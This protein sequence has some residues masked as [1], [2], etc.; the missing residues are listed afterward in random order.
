MHSFARRF[1]FVSCSTGLA[2]CAGSSQSAAD[3][4]PSALESGPVQLV[5]A[6]PVPSSA[7]VTERTEKKGINAQIRYR[8][9]VGESTGDKL[10]VRYDDLSFVELDGERVDTPERRAEMEALAAGLA[11]SLP[12]LIVA[13]NGELVDVGDMSA[14]IDKVLETRVAIRPRQSASSATFEWRRR[15]SAPRRSIATR[16]C[17]KRRHAPS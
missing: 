2:A 3:A 13:R 9:R 12:P 10:E 17:H 15:P 1:L 4:A 5:F 6:W 8:I 14:A 11:A 7:R 16:C